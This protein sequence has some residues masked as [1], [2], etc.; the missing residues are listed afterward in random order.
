MRL[1]SWNVNGI[2]AVLKKGFLDFVQT[3]NPDILCLQEVR[4][5][6]EQVDLDLQGYH[7]FW[8]PAERPGYSGTAVFSRTEPLGARYG[9]GIGKHD[10]EG[11]VITLEYEDFHL[12]TVY[13][14]NSKGDLSRLDYRGREWDVAFLDYVRRLEKKKPVV[15]CG[16]LN[17]A[18]QEIDLARPKEN[19]GCNGFTDEEREGFGNIVQAGFIDTFREFC[20]EG[21]HYTWWS[22]IRKAREKNLGWRIDY[23]C[24]SPSLRPRLKDASILAHVMGSDHCPVAIEM[25]G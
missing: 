14:P 7:V 5:R 11:R 1:I 24:I 18:H 4:A 19:R 17:V 13:T 23:F 15:F 25:D 20:D 2:R 12:V 8:N 6:P 10:A 21:S 3:E 9:M 22:Y 16:D